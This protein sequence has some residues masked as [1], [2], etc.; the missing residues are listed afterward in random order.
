MNGHSLP[1]VLGTRL[2]PLLEGLGPPPARPQTGTRRESPSP[3]Q[4][5]HGPRA[6]Q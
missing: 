2:S 5:P 6:G 4:I 1:S 3:H